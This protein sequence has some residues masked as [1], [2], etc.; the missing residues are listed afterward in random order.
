MND[1]T[2]DNSENLHAFIEEREAAIIYFSTPQC[3]VCKVLKPKVI[4]LL[5][6]RFPRMQ[7]KYIDSEALPKIAAAYS[8]FA[9]PTVLIFFDG[10]ETLRFSRN[11]GLAQLEDAIARPYGLMFD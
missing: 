8:V 1:V 3:N 2:D 5:E 11:L 6:Q 10:H 9:V 4:E 7:F